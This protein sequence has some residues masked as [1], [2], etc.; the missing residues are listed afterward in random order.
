MLANQLIKKGYPAYVS[1][2]I[3]SGG[4]SIFRIRVS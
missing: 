4:R 1:G 3:P 2:P